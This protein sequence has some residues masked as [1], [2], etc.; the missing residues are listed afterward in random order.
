MDY[1]VPCAIR[2]AAALTYAWIFNKFS[3]YVYPKRNYSCLD[4][5]VIWQQLLLWQHLY[6]FGVLNFVGVSQPKPIHGFSPIFRIFLPQEDLELIRFWWISD[7]PVAMST[8]KFR[9]FTPPL[10]AVGVLFSPMVSGWAG[11]RQEK[12]CLACISETVRCRKLILGRDI[13]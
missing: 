3:G 13:G 2:A 4:F 8:V 10:R 6:V 11:R 5:A 7:S 1:V 9:V 12:V